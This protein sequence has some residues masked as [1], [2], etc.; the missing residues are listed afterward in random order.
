MPRL[1]RDPIDWEVGELL[2]L[3]ETFG[4]LNPNVERR[5][6]WIWKLNQKGQFTSKSLYIE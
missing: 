5:D 6:S 4:N 3:L 1:R 2:N